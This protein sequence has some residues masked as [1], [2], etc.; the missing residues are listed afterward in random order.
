MC[1]HP[2]GRHHSSFS[3]VAEERRYIKHGV[4][5]QAGGRR[6]F[7]S[8]FSLHSPNPDPLVKRHHDYHCSD[9][10][11]L[12]PW[13]SICCEI[14][15]SFLGTLSPL[16]ILDLWTRQNIIIIIFFLHFKVEAELRRHIEIQHKKLTKSTIHRLFATTDRL[17]DSIII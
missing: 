16:F 15:I 13:G 2:I 6:I 8:Y 4:T 12:H 1:C 11:F 14:S 3:V 9:R 10:S 5:V 7:S 17:L